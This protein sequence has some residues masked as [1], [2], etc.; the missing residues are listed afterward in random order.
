MGFGRDQQFA[1]E[2]KPRSHKECSEPAT[3][4]GDG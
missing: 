1:S 2:H 3:V 4:K